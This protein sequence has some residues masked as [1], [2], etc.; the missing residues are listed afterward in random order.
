MSS[1]PDGSPP[2]AYTATCEAC[3]PRETLR[4]RHENQRD[5]WSRSH[6]SNKDH[7]VTRGTLRTK[8]ELDA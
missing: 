5:V 6:E 2:L 7:R 3:R 8:E 4:F 1:P